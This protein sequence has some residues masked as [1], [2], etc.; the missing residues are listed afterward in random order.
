MNEPI[1]VFLSY[2]HKDE[3]LRQELISHLSGLQHQGLI[4]P[5][6]DRNISAGSEWAD[7]IDQNLE[8]ADIILFLVSADF[9]NSPYCYSIEMKRALER[10]RAKTA[11]TIPVIIR[12]CDW[13]ST[14]LHQL[15]GIPRD[16][17]HVTGWG[18]KFARDSAWR[19]VSEEIGKVARQIWEVRNTQISAAQKAK[20][21]QEFQTKAENFYAD[22][23]MSPTEQ[24]LLNRAQQELGLE[25]PEAAEILRVVEAAYQQHQADLEDYRQTL[26]DELAGQDELRADQRALLQQLQAEFKISDPEADQI[27]REVLAERVIECQKVQEAADQQAQEAELQQQQETE[28]R[29]SREAAERQRT[30]EAQRQQA[31]ENLQRK[32]D[33]EAAEQQRL[34]AQRQQE[35]ENLRQ[36]QDREAAEL[37]NRNAATRIAKLTLQTF[38]FEVVLLDDAGKERTRTK[39]QAQY[40]AEILVPGVDLHM[41]SIPGGSFQMGSPDGEGNDD[42]R[43]QHLVKVAPFFMGKFPVTQAQ[44]RVV[45]DYPQVKQAL[46][47]DPSTFKGDNLPVEQV[48]WDD[49]VEFCARLSHKTGCTYRLPSEAEWEYACRA[50]TNTPYHFGKKISRDFVNYNAGNIVTFVVNWVS[51]QTSEVGSFRVANQFGLYDMHGNVSEWC[52]D[53]WHKDYTGAPQDGSAWVNENDNDKRLLRGGAWIINPGF[54]RSAFRIAYSSDFR[55]DDVGFRVVLVPS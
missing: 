45:A 9:I 16:N 26:I 39:A 53:L 50:N 30:L 47:T 20:A 49:A 31:A 29:L 40:F 24:R 21:R 18:D 8:Q 38:S 10:H 27:E 19:Q 34:E 14:D 6:H 7:Q 12:D 41:V 33:L 25:E 22:G 4:E 5:W 32:Q 54:C 51:K 13:K 17:R 15:N 1:K 48:S 44:W 11:C 37:R 55:N 52:L 23:V 35:A 3:E 42:E 43:P 28:A 36:K 46:S 2:S